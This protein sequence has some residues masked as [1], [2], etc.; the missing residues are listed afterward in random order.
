MLL[1]HFW[2]ICKIG[3]SSLCNW[4]VMF[5]LHVDSF[6]IMT[7]EAVLLCVVAES[8]IWQT[9]T[10]K[11]CKRWHKSICT[12]QG[13]HPDEILETEILLCITQCAYIWL[14]SVLSIYF[15]S[16]IVDALCIVNV[17]HSSSLSA[18]FLKSYGCTSWKGLFALVIYQEWRTFD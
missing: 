1:Q 3:L 12:L 4:H 7:K 18:G 14:L 10:I 6:C 17:G 16:K 13:M 2:S 11:N 8:L 9:E 5:Y 15:C